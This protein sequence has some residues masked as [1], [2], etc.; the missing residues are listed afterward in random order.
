MCFAT[1]IGFAHEKYKT[2]VSLKRSQPRAFHRHLD[3]TQARGRGGGLGWGAHDYYRIMQRQ[4]FAST[5]N[6]TFYKRYIPA[7]KEW[8]VSETISK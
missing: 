8:N 1:L 4:D 2:E 7:T 3:K 6:V 5:L